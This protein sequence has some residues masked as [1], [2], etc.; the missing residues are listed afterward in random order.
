MDHAIAPPI[1]FAAPDTESVT[2]PPSKP[3]RSPVFI[4][5]AIT[6][7]GR[8][9]MLLALWREQVRDQDE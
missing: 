7:W 2:G 6:P 3:R 8:D 4:H 1:W 9:T 5:D